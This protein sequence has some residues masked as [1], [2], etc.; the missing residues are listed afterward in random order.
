MLFNPRKKW[1]WIRAL[2]YVFGIS[3]VFRTSLEIIFGG[4]WDIPYDYQPSQLYYRLICRLFY[5]FNVVK[6][7]RMPSSYM[8]KDD[9][10]VEAVFQILVDFFEKEQPYEYSSPD[11]QEDPVSHHRLIYLYH[12]VKKLEQKEKEV[13]K[14]LSN[15][16]KKRD[17]KEYRRVKEEFG[18]E[19]SDRACEIIQLRKIMWT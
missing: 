18:Q 2:E 10:V 1:V 16:S 11:D 4:F 6:I 15:L 7:Q 19:M 14:I 8:D 17:H 13:N 9:T 3:G 5:K 12:W